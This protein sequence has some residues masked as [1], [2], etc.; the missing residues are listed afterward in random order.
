M[1]KG[2]FIAYISDKHDVT[3]I[4][5]EKIIDIFTSST[6]RALGQGEEISLVGFGKFSV[7]KVKARNGRNPQTGESLKIKAYNQPKFKVGQNLKMQL[8]TNN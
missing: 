2:D 3:K 1:N 8:I 4:K 5:A 7:S 6:I